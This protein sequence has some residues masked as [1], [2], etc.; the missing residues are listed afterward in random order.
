MFEEAIELGSA[1][2]L[3]HFRP[4]AIERLGFDAKAVLER[5]PKII[6]LSISGVGEAGPYAHKRVYDPVVQAL[7]GLADVQAD[8]LSGRPRM[9]RTLIADQTTSI[10]AAQAVTAALLSRTRS[11][12]GQHV[13]L[14]M[15]DTMVS[16]LWPEGMAPF[17]SVAD[18]TQ[19]AR[20]SSHDMIFA[21]ADGFITLGAVSDRE[22]RALCEALGRP[23]WID[24]PRFATGPARQANRQERLEAVE[25]AL[26]G[27]ETT[28]ILALLDG[29]DV[30]SAPVL[31]R[32]QMIDDAQVEANG[33]IVEIEQP[34]SGRLRQARPAARFEGTPAHMP[35]PAPALGE[36]TGEIL[37]E[38]GYDEQ[39]ITALR[40]EGVGVS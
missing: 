27:R 10:Y 38:L 11:G 39:A 12:K 22:W 26:V 37:R 19:T 25:R 2:A 40:K 21:T 35:R 29:A 33:L 4:G 30:P 7:S 36:H 23:E 5:N 16:F 20:A 9:V 34:G 31:T 15:L 8:P 6:Y 24:D 14:S 28:E 32:R 3:I 1:D 13:R 17:A 18:D